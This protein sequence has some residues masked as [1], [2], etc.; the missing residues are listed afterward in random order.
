MRC[1]PS[2]PGIDTA[3][4]NTRRNRLD[5][6]GQAR[7]VPRGRALP[8]RLRRRS[9]RESRIDDRPLCHQSRRAHGPDER[10][11]MDVVCELAPCAATSPRPASPASSNFPSAISPGPIPPCV[12]NRL[13]S[14][15]G[16]RPLTAR[17]SAA[18]LPQTRSRS[19]IA[20]PTLRLNWQPAILITRSPLRSEVPADLW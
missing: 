17:S 12:R 3:G 16:M 2:R 15:A 7:I 20:K 6:A 9:L 1:K 8:Q 19:A 10:R 4:G 18:M 13:P 5:I 11:D 14:P